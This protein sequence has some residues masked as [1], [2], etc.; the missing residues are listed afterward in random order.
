MKYSE[1]LKLVRSL[2]MSISDDGVAFTVCGGQLVNGEDAPPEIQDMNGWTVDDVAREVAS[3]R[4]TDESWP[5][6]PTAP[7]PKP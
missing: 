1:Q 6:G 5:F 2:G 4:Q 3:R 7:G